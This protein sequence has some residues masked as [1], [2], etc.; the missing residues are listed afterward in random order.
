MVQIRKDSRTDEN[1]LH[2]KK[3]GGKI[4]TVINSFIGF[5]S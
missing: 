2:I 1:Y 3:M 5:T 4:V